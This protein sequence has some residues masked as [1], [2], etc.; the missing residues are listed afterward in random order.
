MLTQ[1]PPG[2]TRDSYF[3]DFSS[4]EPLEKRFDLSEDEISLLK[5]VALRGDG[6]AG[7]RLYQY[8]TVVVPNPAL[9]EEAIE[10]GTIG[11][12]I[13]QY[14]IV[15][16]LYNLPNDQV[17]G[18]ITPL[19]FNKNY[20]QKKQVVE[21]VSLSSSGNRIAAARLYEYYDTAVVNE[22]LATIFQKFARGDDSVFPEI[23]A[24]NKAFQQG[25]FELVRRSFPR[26]SKKNYQLLDE[27]WP[28]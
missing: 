8:Y 1:L 13:G 12:G 20:L 14:Y 4:E 21:L 26:K 19:L 2:R 7:P 9:A 11:N 22:E 6:V 10:M 25:D 17:V 23:K 16:F 28:F 18:L 27:H 15:D 24:L 3:Y 5:K